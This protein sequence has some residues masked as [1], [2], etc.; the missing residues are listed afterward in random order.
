IHE[1]A[2]SNGATE[3]DC[4][5]YK[6]TS[7]N[8]PNGDFAYFP[9]PI[10]GRASLSSLEPENLPNGISPHSGFTTAVTQGG[11]A[12][13]VLSKY[14]TI[15]F[16]IPAGADVSSL[17]IMY[18]DGSAWV[19][20]SNNLDLGGGKLVGLGGFLNPDGTHFQATVNFTGG[21]ILVSK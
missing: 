9:C 12:K 2:A 20:L 5:Q 14:M 13:T 8:L 10:Q 1:V 15:S 16:E 7:L 19:E 4:D 17:A 18:W 21:F 6:G 3:L 11:N